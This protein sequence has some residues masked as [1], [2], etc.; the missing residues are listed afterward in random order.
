MHM[1]TIP[2][3]IQLCRRNSQLDPFVMGKIIQIAGQ[4]RKIGKQMCLSKKSQKF[5]RNLPEQ[6]AVRLVMD[7]KTPNQLVPQAFTQH[8]LAHR[9]T[10][11]Q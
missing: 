10:A 11:C 5:F 7:K 2:V 6:W 9:E 3:V 1:D 4:W 8:L